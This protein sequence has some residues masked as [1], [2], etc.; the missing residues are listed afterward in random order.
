M[1]AIPV[2]FTKKSECGHWDLFTVPLL[3]LV[4]SEVAVTMEWFVCLFDD[5]CRVWNSAHAT[6][7]LGN[8]EDT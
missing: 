6:L 4:S 8:L 3:V 5:A 2:S 7:S 1:G